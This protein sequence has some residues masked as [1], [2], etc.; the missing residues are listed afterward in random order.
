MNE[1]KEYSHCYSSFSQVNFNQ[2]QWI[3][4]I[5]TSIRSIFHSRFYNHS[6]FIPMH[7]LVCNGTQLWFETSEIYFFFSFFYVKFYRNQVVWRYFTLILSSVTLLSSVLLFYFFHFT[8]F[9]C[10]CHFST[11]FFVVNSI[12][13]KRQ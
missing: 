2:R 7:L 9:P 3:F 13:K 8:F 11:I 6:H 10:Y 12:C 1:K 4:S 5:F